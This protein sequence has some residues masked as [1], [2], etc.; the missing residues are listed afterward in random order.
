[1]VCRFHSGPGRANHLER[2]TSGPPLKRA[3]G[4]SFCFCSKERTSARCVIAA[5]FQHPRSAGISRAENGCALVIFGKAPTFCS[6]EALGIAWTRLGS[7]FSR[8]FDA[9]LR[10]KEGWTEPPALSEFAVN[11]PFGLDCDTRRRLGSASR[12]PDAVF[13]LRPREAG[14]GGVPRG[15]C[16]YDLLAKP[17]RMPSAGRSVIRSL[18][19]GM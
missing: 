4:F 17:H 13:T 1:M 2:R 9:H 15:R 3:P 12:R 11:S 5:P 16:V 19:R 8:R 18:G 6:T 7:A 10:C 14:P